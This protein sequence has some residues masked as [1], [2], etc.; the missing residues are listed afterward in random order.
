M[1]LL[2]GAIIILWAIL[3]SDFKNLHKP[4]PIENETIDSNDTND[5]IEMS[6]VRSP[7]PR[8]DGT[9]SVNSAFNSHEGSIGNDEE[10]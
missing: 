5:S 4:A 8:T 6:N 2:L 3:D 10:E 1:A 9:G 7:L